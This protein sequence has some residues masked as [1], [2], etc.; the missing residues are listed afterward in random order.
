[1]AKKKQGNNIK[2]QRFEAELRSV[3]GQIVRDVKDPRI[4]DI[5]TVTDTRI[6]PDREYATV[7]FSF[8]GQYDVKE[9][10]KGLKSAKGYIRSRLAQSMDMRV[11]PDLNFV[12]D[13]SI[14]RGARIENILKDLNV[15]KEPEN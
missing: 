5:L 3:L 10:V 13:E 8:L 14:E 2:N 7:Y 9:V 15:N 4:P 11:V 1:M 6:S 12:L